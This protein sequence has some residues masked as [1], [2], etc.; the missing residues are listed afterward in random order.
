MH[1]FYSILMLIFCF[2][3][4]KLFKPIFLLWNQHLI[5]YDTPYIVRGKMFCETWTSSLWN[6]INCSCQFSFKTWTCSRG[7][8]VINWLMS[9]FFW[10]WDLLSVSETSC[11]CQNF[12]QQFVMEYLWRSSIFIFSVISVTDYNDINFYEDINI[13]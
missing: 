11:S 6:I 9:N 3:Y 4:H 7:K 1:Y 10:E 12:T 8:H 2:N 13:P 5:L